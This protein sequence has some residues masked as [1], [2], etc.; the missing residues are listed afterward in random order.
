M[1][2]KS[3]RFTWGLAWHSEQPTHLWTNGAW[4]AGARHHCKRF[5]ARRCL[6]HAQSGHRRIIC[7]AAAGEIIHGIENLSDHIFSAL[8]TLW[9]PGGRRFQEALDSPLLAPGIP[10]I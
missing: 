8:N 3:L 10:G 2:S 1:A 4:H 7:L 6:H 5:S 9:F